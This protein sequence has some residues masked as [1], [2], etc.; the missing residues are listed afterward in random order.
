MINWSHV[1][2]GSAQVV[3]GEDA[4]TGDVIN[5][6]HILGWLHWS[7]LRRLMWSIDHILYVINWSHI[8]G[9]IHCS[10]LRR[11]MWSIRSCDQLI[12]FGGWSWPIGWRWRCVLAKGEDKGDV[13]IWSNQGQVMLWQLHFQRKKDHTRA[14]CRKQEGTITFVLP[15]C[16]AVN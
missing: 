12:T 7:H 2:G 15:V 13:I 8:L 3:D 5:W 16:H 11:F 14:K 9:W 4:L 6:S 10:H 1:V